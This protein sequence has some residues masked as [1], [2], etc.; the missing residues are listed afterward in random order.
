M[1]VP[2]LPEQLARELRERYAASGRRQLI[3]LV[4]P[5]GTGK[6]TFAEHLADYFVPGECV[7]VPMDGFHLAQS[8]IDGTPRAARRGAIDTF[9]GEG[10]LATLQRL[11]ART[12]EVVYVPSYRRGLEEP[13]AASIAVPASTPIVLTE[14]NYLLAAREPWTRIR[15]LLDAAWFIE[16]PREIR[17]ARLIARHVAFGK[18]LDAATAWALGPDEANAREIEKSR[19]LADRVIDWP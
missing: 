12:D 13:I 8:I 2:T 14:G 19:D 15:P 18:D 4:G 5:P 11:R 10:Y 1:A 16:T 3:G 7:I 9:D 6:S 17:I